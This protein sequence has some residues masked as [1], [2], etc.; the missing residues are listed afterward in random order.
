MG[1]PSYSDIKYVT[2]AAGRTERETIQW[3][4]QHPERARLGCNHKNLFYTVSS[5]PGW[6]VVPGLQHIH[7]VG[8]GSKASD[9]IQ[10]IPEQRDAQRYHANTH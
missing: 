3:V 6:G 5:H 8:E 10:L 4:P 7:L 1:F 9:S 2:A